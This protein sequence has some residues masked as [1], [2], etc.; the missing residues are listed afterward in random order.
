MNANK[1]CGALI[2]L[3]LEGRGRGEGGR[4]DQYEQLPKPATPTLPVKG[5]GGIKANN[6]RK[7]FTQG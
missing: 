5:E 6:L 7:F 2:P 1:N 4:L 3:S